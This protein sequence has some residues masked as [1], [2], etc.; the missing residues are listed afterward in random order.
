MNERLKE[1][2]RTKSNRFFVV[3]VLFTFVRKENFSS[4][5]EMEDNPIE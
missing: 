1:R 3:W 4:I 2:K 5:I